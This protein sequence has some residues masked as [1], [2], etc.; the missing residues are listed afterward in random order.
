MDYTMVLENDKYQIMLGR[1]IVAVIDTKSK[2][3][4]VY[5]DWCEVQGFKLFIGEDF[6]DAVEYGK[7]K[8]AI[9]FAK[10]YI[11]SIGKHGKIKMN[12]GKIKMKE[13]L[14]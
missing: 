14:L 4:T 11:F 13:S 10:K 3:L 7:L 8:Q 12:N 1:V 2:K 6:K 5:N 9:L